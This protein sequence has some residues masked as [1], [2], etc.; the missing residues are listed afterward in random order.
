[1]KKK[2]TFH[3]W[4]ITQNTFL[5]WLCCFVSFLRAA[6]IRSYPCWGPVVFVSFVTYVTNP[7]VSNKEPCK[8][9]SVPLLEY[10]RNSDHCPFSDDYHRYARFSQSW[11][12]QGSARRRKKNWSNSDKQKYPEHSTMGSYYTWLFNSIIDVS[13]K[14]FTIYFLFLYVVSGECCNHWDISVFRLK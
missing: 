13:S 8:S 12:V 10:D 11:S 4:E 7:E 1:M 6:R 3:S 9:L 2:R 5:L 14:H